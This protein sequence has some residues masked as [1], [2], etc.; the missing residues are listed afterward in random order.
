[1][2]ANGWR[3]YPTPTVQQ[4]LS[5]HED[6]SCSLPGRVPIDRRRNPRTKLSKKLIYNGKREEHEEENDYCRW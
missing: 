2:T 3:P 5:V 4:P 1:M 6:A